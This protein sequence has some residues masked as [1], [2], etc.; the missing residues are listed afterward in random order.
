MPLIY[1]P[2]HDL[3]TL[4]YMRDGAGYSVLD[5]LVRRVTH[6]GQQPSHLTQVEPPEQGV[7]PGVGEGGGVVVVPDDPVPAVGVL[8]AHHDQI[9]DGRG[10]GLRTRCQTVAAVNGDAGT[11]ASACAGAG[12]PTTA[13]RTPRRRTT[14]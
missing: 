13:A 2:P 1:V 4:R 8:G 14:R 10:V 9:G 7:A 5:Q 11:A 6:I 3:S 12:Q